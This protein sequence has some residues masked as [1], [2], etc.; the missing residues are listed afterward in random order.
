MTDLDRYWSLPPERLLTA[1]RASPE[2]LTPQA[3]ARRLKRYGRNVLR[4]RPRA[5]ALRLLLRQFESP[6]ILILVFAAVVAAMVKDWT[7]ASIVLAIVLGS[8]L[9]S[10]AQEHRATTAVE[11]LRAQVRVHTT[12]LRAGK[13]AIVPS[14]E[15]VPGDIVL[16]SAGS[17]VPADGV[18]L[19]AK[20]FFVTQSVLTGEPLPV[21]KLAGLCPA[22]A[23]LAQRTNSVFMGT[24]VRSG[25]AR[26]LILRTGTTTVYGGIADQLRLR[27]PETEFERG[28]R[29]Y[30]YLLSQIMLLLVLIVFAANVFLE[31][32]PVDSLLFAIALAVGLSPE[33]LPAIISVTLS[34]GAR[35]MA[36]RGVIVR[37]LNAIEN[38]GSMDVLCSDKT[39]TLTTGVMALDGALDPA[40]QTSATV[41]RA[42]CLN[43]ALQTGLANPLDEA[44]VAKAVSAGVDLSAT[45]KVDEIPYDFVRKRLSIVV[46]DGPG[47]EPVMITK[48][49]VANVVEICDRV[50]QPTGSKPLDAA[51]RAEIERLFAA[52][53]AV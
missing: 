17:L 15:I 5:S 50:A 36:A 52:W 19:E 49:A 26:V 1:L 35:D 48:G 39:G 13:Q 31:R 21:E 9:L 24:S 43:A 30:G 3:A 16:L 33:L 42:A 47:A 34:T 51:G 45:H 18:V 4:A 27:P 32:P 2:G 23:S 25:T 29:R 46:S 10:F 40:G 37:R 8:G 11:R 6:L 28:I 53:S 22:E 44:I 12:V 38:F 14:E 20:D 41:L 7:D